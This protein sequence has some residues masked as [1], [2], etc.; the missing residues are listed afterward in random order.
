MLHHILYSDYVNLQVLCVCTSI[1]QNFSKDS[2]TPQAET[3][4]N[5]DKQDGGKKKK[6]KSS[7]G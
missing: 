7:N 3:G 2:E 1:L 4:N 5:D 6:E